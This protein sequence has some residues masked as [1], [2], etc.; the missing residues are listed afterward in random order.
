MKLTQLAFAAAIACAL[1]AH[2]TDLIITNGKVATMSKEGAFAQAL[3]IKD[4]KI[5][6]VGS[7]AQI[8]KL[9][10]STTQVIDAA[11]KTVIPGLNDSHLHIIREGLNYNAELRWDG[12]TSLKKALQMLK[13][14]AARTPDGAW[15]KV[16][17]G[18]NEYQF[19]EKRLPTLEEINAAVPDKPVFI[20]YLYGL[21]YLNQKGIA[22][23]GYNADTKFKDGVVE[24]GAD[25][26]PTGMLIAKPNA[27]ILYGTLA[28]TN[29]LPRDEQLNSTQQYYTELNRLGLTSAIDAGGGGQAYPDDYAVSLELARNGKLTVRTSYYLFAQKPGKELE[30]Y[31]R[32]LTQTHPDKNDH[33]FYANG[34]NTEGGGEN[35]VWSAADFEN[36]LEPRPDMPHEMEG[37]LEPVLRLLI[38]N[39]WPFRIHATYDESIDRDLAVIEKVNKDTP[40]NGLRWFFDHA[41]TIS[42]KQL[43]RVKALGGGIA[44]QNRMYFQGELYWK[45]YGAQT[46]QMP[47]IKKMLEMKI[48]VGL[49][50]DGT[51]V[52]SYG[53]WPSIYWAVS[54]KTAGGLEIWQRKDVLS[55]YQALKLMTQ[56]SAWM[57][58]EEKL[59]GT[60][61]KGQYADLV[62]LPQDYFT[63]DVEQIKN[64]ES[65]LTIVNGKVVYAAP[66]YEQYGPSKPGVAPDWSP[67]K[68]YGGYQNK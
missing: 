39:R 35:L 63:M 51:R 59:K 11:G 22:T 4:G 32:W 48:P 30:D 64:L 12:V 16:V 27:A 50:T 26:K 14:Q 31:Q 9:K 10:S 60:L 24:L 8:L 18:W 49:G 43:A 29:V 21:G 66:E 23:L 58:G 28:K 44:V 38:K 54:G 2:A 42:D 34:Y 47:P 41:E 25:G 19:E 20:L 33:L 46:R 53:P 6:A 61:T 15:I 37:E 67:V 56:G 55:R 52:S 65:S 17:G 68:Y 3:A 62:I 5:E 7:N 13:E 45:Q 36:F 57:S 40:L 1:P